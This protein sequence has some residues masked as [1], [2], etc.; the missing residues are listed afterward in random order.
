MPAITGTFSGVIM[1][2]SAIAIPEQPLHALVIAAV[3]G[4]HTA[5]DTPWDD[6]KLVYCGMGDLI[7]G[8]GM[9][10]G[11]FHNEHTNG[12]TTSGTFEAT[13]AMSG[14]ESKVEGVWN[15]VSG[16]GKFSGITGGG[17]FQ[18]RSTTPVTVEM[19][20]EGEYALPN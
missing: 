16:T 8:N 1:T 2:Q 9:Q 4:H 15:L 6:A 3:S 13:V 5:P 11:Y 17:K 20:W 14:L 12:D 7:A 10:S 19:T 18:A